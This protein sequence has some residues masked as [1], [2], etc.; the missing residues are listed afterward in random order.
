M[1]IQHE[2]LLNTTQA[3][4]PLMAVDGIIRRRCHRFRAR[5]CV[6]VRVCLYACVSVMTAFSASACEGVFLFFSLE[7]YETGTRDRW[8]Q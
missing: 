4:K 3:E 8:Q 7:V 6:C 5:V 1:I 2:R